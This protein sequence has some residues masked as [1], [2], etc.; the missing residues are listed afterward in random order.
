MVYSTDKPTM[1]YSKNRESILNFP[2]FI[3]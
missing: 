3:I 1:V 2:L